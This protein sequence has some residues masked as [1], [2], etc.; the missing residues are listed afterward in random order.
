MVKK[1]LDWNDLQINDETLKPGHENGS[2]FFHN[3]EEYYN[4]EE[5]QEKRLVVL[6]RAKYQCEKCGA[7]LKLDI[8]HLTYKNLYHEPPEDLMALCRA[9]HEAA[10]AI[11]SHTN[12]YNNALD[13]Y[14]SKKYGEDFEYSEGNEEEF[15]HWIGSKE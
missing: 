1:S 15:D 13:T 10:D 3:K 5:W 11:R 7:N 6:H 4:S 14:M 12:R 8:H 9:C 2:K